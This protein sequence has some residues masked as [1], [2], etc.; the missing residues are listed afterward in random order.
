MC[1]GTISSQH[2]T[3][4]SAVTFREEISNHMDETTIIYCQVFLQPGINYQYISGTATMVLLFFSCFFFGFFLSSML[5]ACFSRSSCVHMRP[6]RHPI[7]LQFFFL[8]ADPPHHQY[9]YVFA[10]SILSAYIS[11]THCIPHE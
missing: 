10:L 8:F 6:Q 4:R 9:L 7:Y 1:A 2:S 11:T 5:P 3:Q